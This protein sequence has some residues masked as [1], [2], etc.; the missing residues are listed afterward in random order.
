MTKKN[1]QDVLNT[2]EVAL[3]ISS[4]SV[5]LDTI[6]DNV[7]GWDS[8]GHLS[9]LMALDK[10]FEGKVANINEIAEANS[11]PKILE[12]LRKHSLI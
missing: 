10:L 8:I 7:E 4:G 5:A 9:I 2:I 1:E 6:A 11:V 3:E 12:A